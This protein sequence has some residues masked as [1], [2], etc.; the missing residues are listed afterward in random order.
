MNRQIAENGTV[1]YRFCMSALPHGR[2]WY[3][4][5][6]LAFLFATVMPALA[7]AYGQVAAMASCAESKRCPDQSRTVAITQPRH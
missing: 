1:V 3:A 2:F 7:S 5:A 4:L 6:G